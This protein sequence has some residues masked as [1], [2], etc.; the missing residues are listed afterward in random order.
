MLQSAAG[1]LSAALAWPSKDAKLARD[2]V[3]S[4]RARHHRILALDIIDSVRQPE[5]GA[6]GA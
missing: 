3:M 4:V 1:E 6:G 5:H 2:R